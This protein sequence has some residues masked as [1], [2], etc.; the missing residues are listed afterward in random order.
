MNDE[1]IGYLRYYTAS[2]RELLKIYLSVEIFFLQ[3]SIH[4]ALTQL[5]EFTGG[6]FPICESV[7]FSVLHVSV[8]VWPQLV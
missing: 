6:S 8:S 1:L 2:G 7:D 5:G 3:V 4:F